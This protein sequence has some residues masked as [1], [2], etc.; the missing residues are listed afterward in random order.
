MKTK[1]LLAVL[2]VS[3]LPGPLSGQ[4]T[5]A[6]DQACDRGEAVSCDDLG[7]RYQAGMSVNRDLERA[8]NFFQEACDG[9]VMLGCSHLGAMYQS[10]VGVVR[11]V[12][13]AAFLFERA[14]DGDGLLG[15]ANLGVSYE[16]G[17]GVMQD[18]ARAVSLYERACGGGEMLGCHNLGS[19]YR[20]G[21][22]VTEDLAAAASLY[23]RACEGS[24]LLSCLN[25]AVS[26]ERGDG[27]PEDFDIAVGLYQR[28]C[29]LGVALGCNR[30]GIT[31][32]LAPSAAG[33]PLQ[34]TT[35]STRSGWVA[36]NDTRDPLSNAIVDIR[37]LGLQMVTDESGR[38]EFQNLPRGRHRLRVERVGYVVME[39]DLDVPGDREFL[40]LLDRSTLGDRSA[41]GRIIG[42]VL[43]GGREFGIAGVGITVMAGAQP[44]TLSGPQGRFSFTGVQPGLV[45]V[46][47]DRL[48]YAPRTAT[49]IVQPDATVEIA[50]AMSA[51]PI[52]LDPIEVIV[53]SRVLENNGFYQRALTS[54]GTQ[55]TREDLMEFN[56]A[57]VSELFRRIPG[58][59]V[60]GGAVV[61]RRVAFG[62]QCNL[63]IFLD[64]IPMDGWEFDSIPPQYLEAMEVYQGLGIPIQYGPACGVVLLW[65]RVGG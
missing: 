62:E 14:C 54:W 7:L 4:T 27:V 44:S 37:D 17:D 48:G 6:L 36:D 51:R 18:P 12:A 42:R 30:L 11:D 45:D 13:T 39:G 53:R 63:R 24:V 16:H 32:V 35:G 49:V 3:L 20:T 28:V 57:F 25:L 47:F 50:A 60:E 61:G 34:P 21:T 9:G 33:I 56:P 64:G 10:G 46:R 58:V 43:E 40:L 55:L 59:R 2:F 23:W 38:I 15:C 26:Y 65:S 5:D 31:A 41:P 8:G 22:A 52:E 19:M 29:E 1:C